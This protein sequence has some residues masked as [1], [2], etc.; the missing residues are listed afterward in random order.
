MFIFLSFECFYVVMITSRHNSTYISGRSTSYHYIILLSYVSWTVACIHRR[1]YLVSEFTQSSDDD[2]VLRIFFFSKKNI[3][4][5]SKRQLTSKRLSCAWIFFFCFFFLIS[6]GLYSPTWIFDFRKC[7]RSRWWLCAPYFL[8]FI[9][10][11]QFLIA[12]I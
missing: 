6:C 11:S 5:V 10:N 8:F 9:F 3:L 2:C 7:C 1:E 12:I 4:Q